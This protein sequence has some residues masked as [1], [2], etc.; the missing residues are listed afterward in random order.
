M[1][2]EHYDKMARIYTAIE[3]ALA[4]APADATPDQNAATIEALLECA[5]KRVPLAGP[6]G[7]DWKHVKQ[8]RCKIEAQRIQRNEGRAI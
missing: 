5:A 3:I 7:D 4:D 8:L 2:M 6:I 1:S